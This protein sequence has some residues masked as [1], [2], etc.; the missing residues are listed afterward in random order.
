MYMFGAASVTNI[1]GRPYIMMLEKISHNRKPGNLSIK[2][3]SE[4]K[5]FKSSIALKSTKYKGLKTV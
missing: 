4:N 3:V 2:E 5:M 1:M